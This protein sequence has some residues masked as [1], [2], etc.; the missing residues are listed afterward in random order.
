MALASAAPNVTSPR[1]AELP[2]DVVR[3]AQ[4]GD[5]SAREVVLRRYAAVLHGL[6]RRT[7]PGGD[8]EELTQALLGRVLE[9]LPRFDPRGS[10]TLTTWIFS[11]SHHFLIDQ[12]RK[13]HLVVAPLEAADVVPDPR[14]DPLSRAWTG[15]LRD[16]LESAI[17]RLPVEQRRVLVLVHIYEQPLVEVAEREGVPVGTV[18]SRL[19]RARA[20]LAQWLGPQLDEEVRHG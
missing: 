8:V 20:T 4:A 14:P 3:R 1:P 6:V 17:A 15:Q 10:A 5:R 13:S 9:V 12:R 11:V 18:K 16:V 7:L 19:F 2:S